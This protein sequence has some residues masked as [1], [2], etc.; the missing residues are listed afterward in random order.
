[1]I[2]VMA[3]LFAAAICLAGCQQ[4]SAY[5]PTI[6]SPT[7][8]TIGVEP[9]GTQGVTQSPP[10]STADPATPT[11]SPTPRVEVT[12]EVEALYP[13]GP[14]FLGYDGAFHEHFLHWAKDDSYLVFDLDDTIWTVDIGGT[15]LRRVADANPGPDSDGKYRFLYG[16]HADATS[17]SRQIVYAT[18]EYSVEHESSGSDHRASLG[19]EIATVNVDGTGR[20]RL[21]NNKDFE[22]YPAWS[23]DGTQIAFVV[24]H[25]G[26]DLPPGHYDQ[27]SGE[28]YVM[29]AD[30]SDVQRVGVGIPDSVTGVALH[31]PVWSPDSQR[32]AFIVSEGEGFPYRKILYTIRLDG[33]ELSRIGETRGLPTWSP[34]GQEIAFSKVDGDETGVYTVRPDGTGLHDVVK[35]F[36]ASQVS[37]SPGG[38][39]LLFISD[40]AY[41]VGLDGSD[42][43]RVGFGNWPVRAAWSTDGSK[44]AVYYPGELLVTL[45]RD[46]TDLRV[47]AEGNGRSLHV[48]RPAPAGD[49]H[50]SCGVFRRLC[51]PGAGSE[52]WFGGRLRD[53]A[54]A[55]GYSCGE[56]PIGLGH[57]YTD[58]R[59]ARCCGRRLAAPCP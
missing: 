39:E 55:P 6:S 56:W 29:A 47:L 37:W 15:Q 43:R 12:Q 49:A 45:G 9:G 46:G 53:A 31:P 18:C 32:L 16:Y 19:Y 22:N 30:G 21:T 4:N 58:Q 5:S 10:S 27:F 8:G 50:R 42:L 35:G 26:R 40:G 17:A 34:D 1:M 11:L 24:Q 54:G 36:G 23:P 3:L 33:S 14:S 20:Q 2:V 51:D 59:V 38:S 57:R 13:C 28:L 25:S 7:V 44:I 41:V 52:S 48:V